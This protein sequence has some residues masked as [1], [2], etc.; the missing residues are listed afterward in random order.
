MLVDVSG[1]REQEEGFLDHGTAVASIVGGANLGVAPKATLSLINVGTSNAENPTGVNTPG[2]AGAGI[3]EA[4]DQVVD[5]IQV[6][7]NAQAAVQIRDAVEA[8]ANADI[9]VV[10]AAGNDGTGLVDFVAEAADA[11]YGGA[12]LVVGSYNAATGRLA[13]SSNIATIEGT[14]NVSPFYLAAPGVGICVAEDDAGA[15]GPDEVETCGTPAEAGANGAVSAYTY[16]NGTSFAAPSVAGAA[17]LVRQANP[18][19]TAAETVQIILDT[20]DPFGMPGVTGKGLLNVAAA[21]QAAG[22]VSP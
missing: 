14:S 21:L 19:L 5:V 1:G 11:R 13:G 18:S 15:V 9:V 4:V 22:Q 3:Q 8:A 10:F 2:A 6:S 20:A 16:R 7:A 12:V 17:A